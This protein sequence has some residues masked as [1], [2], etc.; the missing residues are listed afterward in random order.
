MSPTIQ[1]FMQLDLFPLMAA[2]LAA[3]SCGLLGNFLVL[4]RQSLMGDAISHAV[5][6]GLVAAFLITQSRSPGVMFIGAAISALFTVAIVELIK[7]L[8]RVE[9]GAAMG[10]VFSVLFALGVYLLESNAAS[11]VDLDADCVLHGNLQTLFWSGAPTDW[12]AVISGQSL[13]EV[14]RQVWSLLGTTIAVVAFV[15]LFFKELRIASFDLG[16]STVQG[17]HAGVMHMVLMTFV[18]IA[19]VASFEAVGSILVIAMLICPAAAARLLTDRLLSQV[20]VS[21]VLS[22]VTAVAGYFLASA[23]GVNG[24]GMMAVVSGALVVAAMVFSPSHGVIAKALNQRRIGR[25]VA[26][27]DVLG[28]LWRLAES[29]QSATRQ[30][31]ISALANPVR[32]GRAIERAIGQGL[33]EVGDS[34][35]TLTDSGRARGAAIIRRHRLWEGYLVDEAGLSP[36][37]V[38]DTAEWLEHLDLSERLSLGRVRR[39]DPQGKPIPARD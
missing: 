8:G 37:H 9:P 14:P 35:L 17:I 38:H 33:I 13:Q 39:V 27:E 7:R 11:G 2:L 30:R 31:L 26:I 25:S 29:G 24:A 28:A 3:I 18:A 19:A 23:M 6:P 4:R 21:A 16:I 15:A 10:V 1:R 22:V 5:L 36:D 34:G 12:G 20:L 32:T